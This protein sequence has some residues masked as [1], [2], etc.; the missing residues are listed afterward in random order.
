MLRTAPGF[1]QQH[2]TT[3]HRKQLLPLRHLDVKD[4]EETVFKINCLQQRRLGFGTEGQAC[5][6]Q[7]AMAPSP[8][9][10]GC[11]LISIRH[12]LTDTY[13][14]LRMYFS[15]TPLRATRLLRGATMLWPY[16]IHMPFLRHW[17]PG[18]GLGDWSIWYRAGQLSWWE[19]RPYWWGR[20]QP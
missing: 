20:M 11:L 6:S 14:Q 13:L 9:C 5:F 3:L 19:L 16:F 18:M 7:F 15:W 2:S 1:F 10:P 8:F 4:K 17:L 12:P